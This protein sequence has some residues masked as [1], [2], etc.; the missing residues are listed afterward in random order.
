[1]NFHVALVAFFPFILLLLVGFFFQ[2][3]FS[4]FHF[5]K[6]ITLNLIILS[7]AA[8]LYELERSAY[9]NPLVPH[10]KKHRYENC[11]HII[12]TVADF[13]KFSLRLRFSNEKKRRRRKN[14]EYKK[15]E[16]ITRQTQNEQEVSKTCTHCKFSPFLRHD[17]VIHAY[18]FSTATIDTRCKHD[19]PREYS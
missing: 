19:T 1:M 10:L 11:A 9:N 7:S 12:H 8:F 4:H 3:I 16:K 6:M 15:R 2:Y 13:H 14:E 17:D 18:A 5:H